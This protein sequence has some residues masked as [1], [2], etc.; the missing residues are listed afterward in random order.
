MLRRTFLGC[1]LAMGLS[2]TLRA[3]DGSKGFDEAAA[4]LQRATASGQLAAASL[5]VSRGQDARSQSFGTAR[6]VDAMYLLGSISKPICMTALMALYDQGGFR[7][8]DPVRKFLPKFSGDAREGVTVGH[9]LTHTSGLPDQLADNSTLRKSHAD[10]PEFV[11]HAVRTPL[12]F[13]PG[14]RYQYSSMGILLAARIAEVI[15]KV[16]IRDLVERSVLTPLGMSRSAQGLGKFRL[17]DF[18][19]AQMDGAAPESGGGDPSSI[20]WNWNSPYWRQLGAPWGGT[21]A[22]A[23]DVGRF[24]AEFLFGQGKVVNAST[25]R[26]MTTNQN[27]AGIQ[28]RGLGFNVGPAA[29]SRGCSPQVFGHTGSTGQL[30]WADPATRTICVVLTSLPALAAN[31]HPRELAG[32]AIASVPS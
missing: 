21:H 9:L 7:L 27:P 3:A 25:A 5:Y 32:A 20:E 26:L 31:P 23:P 10:L 30:S 19:P 4:I 11:A 18:I 15:S 6:N 8:D 24:L 29:G 17:D 14:T 28:P 12:S 16:G 1:G 13:P 22:S 2:S